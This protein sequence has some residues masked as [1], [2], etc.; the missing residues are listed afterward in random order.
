[1]TDEIIQ[2]PG[3]EEGQ[4]SRENK[5][6]EIS[7]VSVSREFRDIINRYNLSPTEIFRRG[8]A[9]TLCDM[10][11]EGYI[12]ELNQKRSEFSKKFLDEIKLWNLSSILNQ[13]H[14]RTT[15]IKLLLKQ[16]EDLENE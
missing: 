11:Q 10:G 5:T 2:Q 12:N 3:D 7:S 16:I 4:K 14:K 9:V 13:I 1:M 6:T 8:V 15:E